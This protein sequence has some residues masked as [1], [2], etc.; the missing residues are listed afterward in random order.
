M[1][2]FFVI[3]AD[4][5]NYRFFTFVAIAA[6]AEQHRA[7]RGIRRQRIPTEQ[8]L[9]GAFFRAFL[10]GDATF[11]TMLGLLG[12]FLATMGTAVDVHEATILECLVIEDP[13]SGFRREEGIDRVIS[14]PHERHH[15]TVFFHGT[16]N[17]LM[18]EVICFQ[19]G[20][21]VIQRLLPASLRPAGG[22]VHRYA[23]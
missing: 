6:E 3:L 23:G 16:A 8:T 17:E 15:S 10:H 14:L 11:G 1:L 18:G 22:A 12:A 9:S 2:V 7:F 21:I 5:R 20:D 4:F 13:V 19:L